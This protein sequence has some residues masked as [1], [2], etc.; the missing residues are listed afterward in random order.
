MTNEHPSLEKYTSHTL[1]ERVMCER[2]V[3]DWTD[4]NIFTPV[5]LSLAAFLSHSAGLLNRESWG[6]SLLWGLVLTTASYLQLTE[7]VCG[8]GLYNCLTSTCFLWASHLN[9]IQPDYSQG[10][11][12][13]S[14][15]GCTCYL[16]RCIYF[17]TA[18]PRFNMQQYGFKSVFLFNNINNNNKLSD[19]QQ[20]DNLPKSG[21]CR[22][23]GPQ[24]ET[25]K[26]RKDAL[27]SVN[28]LEKIMNL[29]VLSHLLIDSWPY[30]VL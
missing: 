9:P 6:P 12:L 7:P 17:L 24:N 1:C 2:W 4:C 18:R 15:T 30:W 5:P 29:T 27:L 8:T 25:Q 19:N 22:L 14:S 16:H 13:I 23:G 3:G 10:Y 26:K 21:V 28:D 20:K 11:T